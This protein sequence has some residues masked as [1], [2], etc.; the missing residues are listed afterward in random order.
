VFRD[1]ARVT[2]EA[3]VA[4]PPGDQ[5]VI[6]RG[7]PVVLDPDSARVSGRG[8]AG[9]AIRSLELRRDETPVQPA[10]DAAA[11]Q[12]E[13]DD[14]EARRDLE[15]ERLKTLDF[16]RDLLTQFR[17]ALAGGAIQKP[18]TSAPG[19]GPAAAPPLD[20][21]AWRSGY[22][23]LS[24]KLDRIAGERQ[25]VAKSLETQGVAIE[26]RH[27]KLMPTE[28]QRR[29]ATWSAD[30][31][32]SSPR[33]GTAT[34]ALTSLSSDASWS[35]VYDARLLPVASRL[36]LAAFAQIF[37]TTGE[38]WH[39][40]EVTLSSTQP[41][42]TLDLPKMTSLYLR[43]ARDRAQGGFVRVTPSAEL[44]RNYQ[45]V[46]T[47]ADG[48]SDVDGDGNPNTHGARD[49]DVGRQLNIASIAAQ[50]ET[51]AAGVV[52]RLP[53]RL[54][55]PSD[56]QAHR[57]LVLE[58]D[59]PA[60]VEY[61]AAPAIER[62]VYIV[63]RATLPADLTLLPGPVQHFVEEDLVGRST[64]P[65]VPGGSALQLGFGPEERL[66]LERREEEKQAGKSGDDLETR[67]RF[68]TTLRNQLERP[69]TVRVTER[70]PIS[71]DD[72]I[73]V[74]LDSRETTDGA[75][76]DSK[77]RGV[78]RWTV[79]LP[80]S[81]SREVILAYSVRGPRGLPLELASARP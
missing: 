49:T 68:A 65:A 10:A 26:L 42:A 72:R 69:V 61:Q 50:A 60:I 62:S 34:L 53:G 43:S 64:L 47:L 78:L 18:P 33:G 30:I 67:R 17:T 23:F 12:A 48:V 19:P 9:I 31:L 63:A 45:D 58:R 37:Q 25:E 51:R 81:E 35:P 77:D 27:A 5:R 80:P 32:V 13:I 56:G 79:A 57:H 52:Y 4:L 24:E 54:D 55:I 66:V 28:S 1:R 71:A 70:L 38:D 46:L 36:N 21:D 14:L 11:I 59:L 22:D 7:L 75:S 3:T 29:K 74:A 44:G 40:V 2:R 16:L 76:E 6:F 41:L 8:S 39:D 20:L 73:R 15:Q